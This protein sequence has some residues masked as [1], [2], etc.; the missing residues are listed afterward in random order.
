MFSY[1]SPGRKKTK[2]A[3]NE[4]TAQG[5]RIHRVR[6]AF[7]RAGFHLGLP[8]VSLLAA[9]YDVRSSYSHVQN[10][11][12][13]LFVDYAALPCSGITSAPTFNLSR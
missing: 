12:I 3:L 9:T 11:A 10:N 13:G 4:I 1:G 6:L 2:R 7:S 5:R 8:G